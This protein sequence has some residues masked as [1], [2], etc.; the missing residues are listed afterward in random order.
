MKPS[1][2]K[3]REVGIFELYD[4]ITHRA[5]IKHIGVTQSPGDRRLHTNVPVRG[6][7]DLA[8]LRLRIAG[9]EVGWSKAMG[10]VRMKMPWGDAYTALE[11]GLLDG[12][13]AGLPQVIDFSLYEVLKYRCGPSVV[14]TGPLGVWMNLDKWDSLPEHLQRSL[15]DAMIEVEAWEESYHKKLIADAVAAQ[16]AAGIE[17]IEW[18]PEETERFFNILY[19][20]AWKAVIESDP[21]LGPKLRELAGT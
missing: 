3:M 4:E 20:V 11:R 8:G 1:A 12:L 5:N 16:D 15:M 9:S 6:V 7:D 2:L 14:Y 10:I 21:I 17:Y 13:Y 18:S 19:E